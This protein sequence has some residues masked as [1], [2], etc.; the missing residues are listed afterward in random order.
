[1]ATGAGRGTGTGNRLK[2]SDIVMIMGPNDR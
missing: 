2:R 1:M